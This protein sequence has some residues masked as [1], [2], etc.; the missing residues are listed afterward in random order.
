MLAK[1]VTVRQAVLILDGKLVELP[2]RIVG[3]PLPSI[4]RLQVLDDC[5]RAWMD[6][7][8]HVVE[9]TWILLDEDGRP[10]IALDT[11]GYP[12]LL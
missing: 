10:R 4:V 9:F 8:E 3:G 5:L 1:G 11:L 12:P 7:P 6:A 2:E